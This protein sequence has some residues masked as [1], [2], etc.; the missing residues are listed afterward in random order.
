MQRAH[1]TSHSPFAFEPL[2]PRRLLSQTL[3]ATFLGQ[4]PAF[5]FP[6]RPSQ[7]VVRVTNPG[8][9]SATRLNLFASPTPDLTSSFQLIAQSTPIVSPQK[10]LHLKFSSS[11]IPATGYFYLV[12]Q[13]VPASE[14]G[15]SPSI[16]D[17]SL[18]VFPAPRP[19]QFVS[20]NVDL[21][22]RLVRQPPGPIFVSSHASTRTSATVMV[23]NAGATT[24][25]G[26]LTAAVYASTN[27][28]FDAS[29]TLIGSAALPHVNIPSATSRSLT[30]PLTLP[31]GTP[32][33]S[34]YLFA[35][36][37][38]SG[39][40]PES[41]TSNNT[42]RSLSPLA[43]TN[44]APTPPGHHHHHAHV[45]GGVGIV[46]YTGYDTPI[47]LTPTPDAPTPP[48]NYTDTSPSDTGTPDTPATTPS[49]QP[50]DPSS[51]PASNDS[52]SDSTS[53]EDNSI[54]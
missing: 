26:T 17:D 50:S 5:V 36:V 53:S 14:Q 44:S 6:D 4:L 25:V 40:I 3:S 22:A 29:A 16:V 47:E 23:L 28:A 54:W 32:P 49:T 7:A 48:D 15:A 31:A 30:V 2:E 20:P 21:T 46:D 34:Y 19:T 51:D 39:A 8:P 11:A 42:A 37:N 38:P 33:R 52:S 12:A 35:V 27:Q 18:S 43:V 41:N 9:R 13:L 1:G 24:A 45:A 10:T